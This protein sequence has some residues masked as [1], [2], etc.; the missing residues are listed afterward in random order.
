MSSRVASLALGLGVVVVALVPLYGDPRATPVSHAEWAR[1]MVKALKVDQAIPEGAQASQVFSILSWKN[2]LALPAD[3]YLSGSGVEVGAEHRISATGG[4]GDVSY[5][6]AVVRGGDYRLRLR[7]QG[8]A[9]NPAEAT[10]TPSGETTPVKS[11]VVVPHASW[12]WVE[13]GAVHLDPGVYTTSLALPPGTSMESLELAPPCLAP[14]EPLQGWRTTAITNRDDLATTLVK[15]L[16][17]ESELPPAAQPTEVAGSD[18]QVT[19]GASVSTA[20]AGGP[21]QFTLKAGPSGLQAMFFVDVPEAGLY[22]LSAFGVVAGGQSWLGSAC[23]KAVLCPNS[24]DAA[25]SMAPQWHTVMTTELT[26]G[27]HYFNVTL[28]PGS[29]IERVR[30]EEKKT[31]PA[32]YVATIKRLGFDPGPE[33]P[34]T[35][36]RA[37]DAMKWLAGEASKRQ[38]FSRGCGDALPTQV[39][40]AVSTQPGGPTGPPVGPGGG[41]PPPPGSSGSGQPPI[42]PPGIPPQPPASSTTLP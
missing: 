29:S 21:Q 37:V 35:R 18:L 8:D 26:A 39:A 30:L 6:L 10:L 24:Q 2:S 42:G 14:I 28:G 25:D 16:D 40:Q 23:R 31:T 3:R 1:M 32:D 17:A 11:F 13:M 19:N 27:R 38:L 33:G 5:A 9:A 20:G 36:G 7:V 34:I 22:N 4:T 15:G 41:P 12:G